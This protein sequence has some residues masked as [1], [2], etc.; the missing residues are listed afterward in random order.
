VNVRS[1]RKCVWNSATKCSGMYTNFVLSLM[2]LASPSEHLLIFVRGN[3]GFHNSVGPLA[4]AT[5][6]SVVAGTWRSSLN[7]CL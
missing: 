5:T 7:H 2:A 3:N 1:E 6:G 4:F